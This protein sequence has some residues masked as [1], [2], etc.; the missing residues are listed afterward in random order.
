VAVLHVVLDEHAHG[1]Q[2][3]LVSFDSMAEAL[4]QYFEHFDSSIEVLVAG[5]HTLLELLK[6]V[7]IARVSDAEFLLT[8]LSRVAT[9]GNGFLASWNFVRET[10]CEEDSPVVSCSLERTFNPNKSILVD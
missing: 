10:L 2:D 8:F 4:F 7:T 5:P 6:S 3:T 9:V 1:F